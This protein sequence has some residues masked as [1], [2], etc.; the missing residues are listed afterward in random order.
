MQPVSRRITR[1][2]N[3]SFYGS[4]W[5]RPLVRHLSKNSQ[6]SDSAESRSSRS[7]TK[8]SS[9]LYYNNDYL[10]SHIGSVSTIQKFSD[11]PNEFGAN[12]HMNIDDQMRQE[13]RS[14]LWQFKAPIRYAFAYGSGV[15]S[16]GSLDSPK[17]QKRLASPQIDLIFGVSHAQH[18]H[19]L[20][21]KQNPS[22][23][24]AVKYLGSGAVGY[25]QDKIGAGVY[26]NP[27]VEINGMKI[28][29]G[30]V[31]MD[32]MIDD[33]C[34]W[35]T[36]YLAGRLHKPVKILRDEPRLRFVNQANLLSA[37]RTALLLLPE[38]FTELQLYTMIAGVSYMGDPRMRFGENPMKVSNIVNNQFLQFRQLYSP[39]M[40]DLPNLSLI[41][42]D[43]GRLSKEK[44]EISVAQLAQDM[45]PKRRG[46]M[47][48]RLPPAF[49]SKLYLKYKA[50]SSAKEAA[51]EV[52]PPASLNIS[53]SSS[54][55]E[56][57]QK[58]ASDK[59]LVSQVS[60]CI[61]HTVSGPSLSQSI[62]GILTAG[63]FK[64]IKYS[65]EKLA[66]YR[67]GKKKLN[68]KTNK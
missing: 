40:D 1:L 23:Y 8:R 26:F 55:S 32:T 54:C 4:H 49:R 35:S 7:S 2:T 51:A 29:Y 15:F 42:S 52:H 53:S 48:M 38:K 30:V 28:K 6:N 31:T 20:N 3:G 25:I 59:H 10:E 61:R 22:H 58:I 12:Q 27:F 37:L 68:G 56:F 50:N 9:S 43:A 66:K 41:S 47:V 36:L 33:L 64:S 18:W 24:S 21:M 16:Q 57:E 17:S 46:N 67:L 60:K 62:K 45:D 14:V 34:N 39:L 19:S 5:N 13:L 11:L 63:I 44:S 65:A